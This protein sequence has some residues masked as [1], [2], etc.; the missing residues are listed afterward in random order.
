[1]QFLSLEESGVSASR[2]LRI[3]ALQGKSVV[4][5]AYRLLPTNIASS[6]KEFD[7]AIKVHYTSRNIQFF[8][9]VAAV[10]FSTFVVG[11]LNDNP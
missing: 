2:Y 1:M 4:F 8:S 11:Y 10:V 3:L 9:F 5:G 6:Y 7:L